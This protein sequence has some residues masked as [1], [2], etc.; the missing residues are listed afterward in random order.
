MGRVGTWIYQNSGGDVV[1]QK[2]LSILKDMGHEVITNL[3][4]F[5]STATA[6]KL[7]CNEINMYDLDVFF[8]YNA[9]EQ[10]Q[11]Q[12]YMYE[13][14]DKYVK[15]INNF[16]A[17][18]VSEDKFKT[19]DILRNNGINSTDYFLCHRDEID[20]IREIVKTWGKVV[21]KRVDG[22]GGI[23]MSLLESVEQLD[24][25]LPFLN[26]TDLRFFYI[27]KFV[28]YDGSDFRVDI[29]DNQFIACY[30][31]KAKQG[32]WRTN[33]TSGGTVILRD[34]FDDK[35]IETAKKAAKALNMDVAGVDIIYDRQKQDYVVLEVNGIPAFATPEQEK[36]GLNFN[37]KKIEV[38][39]NLIDKK[40]KG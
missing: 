11:Y 4:L 12:T 31:R 23:G 16:D 5:H 38:L 34:D 25:I 33:V 28:D 18:K 2:L 8:S 21:F 20:K 17:F 35:L 32:D 24:M 10:T 37:N 3:N 14:V 1:E 39:A 9:G 22:W 7:I 19:S 6:G 13:Q 27:E 40:I 36:M 29:V 30:G 15:C 26:Q